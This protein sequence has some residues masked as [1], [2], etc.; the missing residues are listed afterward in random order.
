MLVDLA[1]LALVMGLAMFGFFRGLFSQAWG[2]LALLGAFFG[3]DPLLARLQSSV[4]LSG[5]AGKET[6]FTGFLLSLGVG[7][8]LY[9]A[10]ILLGRVVELVFIEQL[11]VI[12]A[13]NRLFGGVLGTVKGLI[14]AVGALFLLQ[15]FVTYVLRGQPAVVQELQQSRAAQ[16][17]GGYNPLNLIYLSRLKPYVHGG[18]KAPTPLPATVKDPSLEALVKDERFAMAL[19]QRDYQAILDNPLYRQ[20]MAD[21]AVLL[22]L[23]ALRP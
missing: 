6:V 16:Q 7:F 12:S 17:V 18:K 4:G 13:G 9:V 1:F 11:G 5:A 22:R 2:L 3:A 20:A 21:P 23:G 15:C 8:A 14:L 19:E 10:L